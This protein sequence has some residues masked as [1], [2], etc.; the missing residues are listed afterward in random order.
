MKAAA[1]VVQKC[2]RAS[3]VTASWR[4]WRAVVGYSRAKQARGDT[5]GLLGNQARLRRVVH[6]WRGVAAVLVL[7]RLQGAVAKAFWAKTITWVRLLGEGGG[8]RAVLGPIEV[9]AVRQPHASS[10]AL[11]VIDA[12]GGGTPCS[13]PWGG[14]FL[15]LFCIA[16][17]PTPNPIPIPLALW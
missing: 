17:P 9:G 4:A 8:V 12:G 11:H 15:L 7:Q 2:R 10:G 3:G 5:A 13:S 16:L 1:A 14:T 6:G